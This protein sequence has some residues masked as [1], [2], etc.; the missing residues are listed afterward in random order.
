MSPCNTHARKLHCPT[1]SD[2][3]LQQNIVEADVSAL[4]DSV[5]AQVTPL[6]KEPK[7]T[8]PAPFETA[9]GSYVYVSEK[10]LYWDPDS[11]FYYD[12]PPRFTKTHLQARTTGA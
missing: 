8:W 2:Y 3:D 1:F 12:A 7:K 6:F 11:M 4:L 10:G 9:G 5:A